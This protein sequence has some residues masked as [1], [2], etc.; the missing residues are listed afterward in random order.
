MKTIGKKLELDTHHA[1]DAGCYLGS[2]V[3]YSF[4]FQES[5]ERLNFVPQ[6]VKNNEFAKSL[7]NIAWET[8]TDNL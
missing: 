8:Y 1:S 7:K 2:L 6:G 3:W 5:P 4:L